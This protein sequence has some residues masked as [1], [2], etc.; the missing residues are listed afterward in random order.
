MLPDENPTKPPTFF[1]PVTAPEGIGKSVSA[2]PVK[3]LVM[4]P[5]L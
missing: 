2:S 1:R 4:F 5:V 3:E